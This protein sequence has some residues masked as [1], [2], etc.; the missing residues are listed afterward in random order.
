VGRP[1]WREVWSVS[2]H[3]L[4]AV[5][6]HCQFPSAFLSLFYM[7]HVLCTRIYNILRLQLFPLIITLHGP[8]RKH[9]SRRNSWFPRGPI[10]YDILEFYF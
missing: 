10:L 5:I 1:L 9:N 6:V 2:C 4:S 7:S 8:Q 3:S